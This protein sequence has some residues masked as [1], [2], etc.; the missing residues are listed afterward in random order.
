VRVLLVSALIAAA[1]ALAVSPRLPEFLHPPLCST[2]ESGG[3]VIK[4]FCISWDPSMGRYETPPPGVPA[5]YGSRVRP[6]VDPAALAV[7]IFLGITTALWAVVTLLV[8]RF[9]GTRRESVAR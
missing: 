4:S 6:T 3:V 9:N 1:V 5:D 7:L 8:R 2:V